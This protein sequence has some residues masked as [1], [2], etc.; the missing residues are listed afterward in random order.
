MEWSTLVGAGVLLVLLGFALIFL[1]VLR[2]SLEG[3]GRV[4]G[5]GVVM[6]GP[7]PIVFGTSLRAAVAAMVLALALM[8][9]ALLLSRGLPV[10]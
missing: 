8:V 6:V 5:G 2:A 3:G 4:E 9:V 10:R 1:G 7:I